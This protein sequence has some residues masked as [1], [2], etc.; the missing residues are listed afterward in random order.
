M[1]AIEPNPLD[2]SGLMNVF[3]PIGRSSARFV[4]RLRP[5]LGV[6]KVGHAGTLDPFADG[7][8]IAC[9]GRAT[10]LVERIMDL[11]KVYRTV[12]QLGVTN[13]TFDTERPFEPVAGAMPVSREAVE[14]VI[15]QL[16][17]R[18]EQVPPI[19]SAI[20]VGGVFSYNLANRGKSV[21]LTARPVVVHGI[22]INS[23]AWPRLD[24]TIECGRGTY[25]R[26]IARDL[27]ERLACGGVCE[28]LRREAVGPFRS[29]DAINL[30]ESGGEQ[31][32]AALIP[33]DKAVELISKS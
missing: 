3:K 11:P 32:R 14:A 22:R 10:K 25:I 33:L 12:I 29:E 27:G 7:V 9:V 19:F 4:Y 23:Y 2:L 8:L 26:A 15:A 13:E 6:K 31:V 1:N 5:I 17:G 20:R 21:E 18:I 28:T 24:L 16:I 30:D